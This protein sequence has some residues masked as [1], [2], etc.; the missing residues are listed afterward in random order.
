MLPTV[1]TRHSPGASGVEETVPLLVQVLCKTRKPYK[2][3]K[4][5]LHVWKGADKTHR[6]RGKMPLKLKFW[7]HCV[8]EGRL[9]VVEK[10]KIM[11]SL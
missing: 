6:Y 7:F 9:T 10:N 4:L 2:Q 5:C 8:D 1:G 3:K 11:S